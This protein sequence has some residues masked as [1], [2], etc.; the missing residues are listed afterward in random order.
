MK[1]IILGAIL[2]FGVLSC[3]K[4]EM[5]QDQ[6]DLCAGTRKYYDEWIAQT[7]KNAEANGDSKESLDVALK[8]IYDKRDID[9]KANGC[10]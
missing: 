4:E 5:S 1:K 7:K 6:K 10:L 2:L 3:T 8:S 9:M